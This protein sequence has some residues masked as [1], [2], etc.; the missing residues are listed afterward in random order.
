MFPRGLA[1]RK[2][3]R[4]ARPSP[5]FVAVVA[6]FLTVAC[7][8]DATVPP[9]DAGADGG[10]PDAAVD[11]CEGFEVPAR[12][13][14]SACD[15][16]DP[17]DPE[18]L[19][20]CARGSGW[21]GRWTVDAD[22]L[23]AYDFEVE[24]RCDPAAQS[25]TPRRA[26]SRSPLRDPVHLVG[27]GRGL[28]AMA[29][30]SGAVEVY[31]QDRGHAWINRVDT[32][33]DARDPNYPV[34]LGG[35]FNYVV[36]PDGVRSTR[37]EDMPVGEALPRQTRRFGVGY[38]ETETDL[39]GLS[40]RRTVYAPGSD[41]RALIAEVVVSNPGDREARVGLVEHWDPN[42]HQI[43]VELATSDLLAPNITE[44]IDRRRRALAAS[45]DQRVSW[46]PVAGVAVVTTSAREL[47]AGIGDRLDP[48]DVDW[49]PPPVYLAALDESASPDAVW[50]DDRE[51]WDGAERPVPEAVA[52]VGGA[53][54]RSVEI[55]GDGQHA[56]L[57]VRVP[58]VIAPG[59]SRRARFAF[60]YAPAGRVVGD[61]VASLR[62]DL[63]SLR[64]D[65]VAALRSKLVFAAFPGLEDAGAVQREL[66]WAAYNTVANVTYDEYHGVRLLGQGGSYKYVHGL[67][68][69]IG[70]LCLFADAALL[71]DPAIARDTLVYALS[72][73][74]GASDETPWRFPYATTGVGA[75]SDVAIYDMRSDAYWLVPSSVGRYVGMTRDAAF[76][77]REVP[78][79]PHAAG[80]RGTVVAHLG[81]SMEY[82]TETLG[83]GARGLVAMGTGDYADGVT[84]LS[85]EA[86]TPT[87]TSSTF[88]AGLLVGG[89][90][91]AAGVVESRDAA[92]ATAMRELVASQT[93]ALNAEGWDGTRYHRGFVD[94]GNPL[95][96][97]M[98]FVEPQVLPIVAGIVDDARRDLLLDLVSERLETP[99]GQITPVLLSG[100]GGGGVG[101]PQL[102]GV[103]PVANAWVT[104]AYAMRD[105]A[106]GWSS[107]VRNLLARHAVEYPEIWYGI[108]TGP[109]SFFGPEGERPGEADAHLATALTDYP[110]LNVHVHTG[111]LRALVALI[112]VRGTPDGLTIAPR[113]PSETW[114]VVFPRLT[115]RATPGSL[116]GEAVFVA[117][118]PVVMRVAAPA[119]VDP[120]TAVVTVGGVAVTHA[121]EDGLVV[122][123]VE[124][125]AEVP[126]AFEV[127]AP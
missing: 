85:E 26:P 102:G 1:P 30:A 50:L 118:G 48:S 67:D 103:W 82:A 25:W 18:A 79:W 10:P 52:G 73:Q 2:R 95:A 6:T 94:S 113:I 69:A 31:T 109:D 29:H 101:E 42:H 89:L 88:N 83:I 108:W 121:V 63:P 55:S 71:V 36:L 70:D 86:T 120:A 47:P 114:S 92:L 100:S 17:G 53:A 24:Q 107:F 5:A 96:D 45:F 56:I 46:D 16:P 76:L 44:D 87:G 57:S 97:H 127:T 37:F 74:H 28:V 68:G 60:G 27:N 49:F 99:I 64:P 80:E 32:W 19:V 12:P 13:D 4:F 117:D 126:V 20:A 112:G 124:A 9:A 106:E 65:A 78:Y 123:T 81:R 15:D 105:P 93:D 61:E 116:A 90:P 35:G 66:A 14:T 75:F 59:G 91:L 98:L 58:L 38:Y 41:A 22:G 84:M 62:A 39:G 72:T 104:E 21:T 40:V 119:G 125:T 51:L 33:R 122:F 8:D 43:T 7:G 77:D 111:P 110:A 54:A 34:Q 23:P 11:P 3:P 115:L